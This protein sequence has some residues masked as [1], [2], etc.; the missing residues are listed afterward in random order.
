MIAPTRP[1]DYS[2][3]GPIVVPG[4]EVEVGTELPAVQDGQ[5]QRV[6]ARA[7]LLL[8]RRGGKKDPDLRRKPLP[9]Q[10]QGSNR[11]RTDR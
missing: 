9:R 10:D 5:F 4:D 7:G 2:P 8:D 11:T 6:S 1:I 3:N